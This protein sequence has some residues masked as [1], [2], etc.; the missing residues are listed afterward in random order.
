MT[1]E[2][3]KEARAEAIASIQKYF[4]ENMDEPIGNIGAEGLLGFFLEEIGPT[5]YNKGVTDA[6]ARLQERVA[7][8]DIEVQEE[9]FQYWRKQ[10]RKARGR[11]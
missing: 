9:E 1:I 5:I 3:T 2:L 11:R 7:E 4:R 6:Q 10:E 8:I